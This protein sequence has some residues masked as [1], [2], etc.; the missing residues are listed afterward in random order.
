MK[1]ALPKNSKYKKVKKITTLDELN[2]LE[3]ISVRG[4]V[5]HHGWY[6]SWQFRMIQNL[7]DRGLV[8]KV[9]LRKREKL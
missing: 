8:Y 9:E 2:D 6:G 4:K 3:F 1:D 5:Y 7:V